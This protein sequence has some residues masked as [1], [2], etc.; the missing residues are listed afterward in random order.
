[1]LC[2]S[3]FVNI[4]KR[5][6]Q[7][8]VSSP[9]RT[10]GVTLYPL[11]GILSLP[12]NWPPMIPSSEGCRHCRWLR[13]QATPFL[14]SGTTSSTVQCRVRQGRLFSLRISASS[15]LTGTTKDEKIQVLAS[16]D[17]DGV[18]HIACSSY[19]EHAHIV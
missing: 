18:K 17:Q 12:T 4:S 9:Q 1:M 8:A 16:I 13:G 19:E 7:Q 6:K 11:L 14:S 5:L 10:V 15:I 3:C 2:M